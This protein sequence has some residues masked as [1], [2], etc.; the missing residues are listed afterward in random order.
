MKTVFYLISIF[1]SSTLHGWGFYAHKK[2]NE[3]AIFTL[4]KPL[5]GFYK[6]HVD[7]IKE[8]AVDADKRRYRVA[9]EACRH[10]LDGDF[11]EC[12]LPIDTIPK[13][14]KDAV[15]KYSEDTVLA[16]GIVPWYIQTMM[17]RLTE[18]FKNKDLDKILKYSA[19]LGHYIGDCHVPLHTSSNYN[20]QKTNQI[21]IH[22]LWESRLPELFD[23]NYDYFTGLATFSKDPLTQTWQVYSESFGLVDS[24]LKTEKKVSEKFSLDQKYAMEQRG[25]QLVKV[26]SKEFSKAYHLALGDMVEQR[27]RASIQMLGSF[28]YTCW[29]NAGQPDLNFEKK[30]PNQPVDNQDETLPKEQEKMIGR[31]EE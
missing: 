2:I 26:Y 20:G 6:S 14:Y 15:L 16:H 18:A 10:F 9:D 7:Y 11:Y 1:I 31:E 12:C 5:F 19:D 8:H 21:G 4:P 27:M 28:W 22:A 13:Y 17:Y 30:D 3:I 25:T 23:K 29:V 24:V